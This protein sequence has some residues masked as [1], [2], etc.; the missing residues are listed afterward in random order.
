MKNAGISSKMGI[1]RHKL[2]YKILL[3]KCFLFIRKSHPLG[4]L[5]SFFRCFL[6]SFRGEDLLIGFHKGFGVL[7]GFIKISQQPH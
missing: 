1:Y 3:K 6:R 7:F 5:L 2:T 4:W